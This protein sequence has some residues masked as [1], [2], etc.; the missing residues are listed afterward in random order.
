MD[1]SLFVNCEFSLVALNTLSLFFIFSALTII[2]HRKFIFCPCLLGV[3]FAS[4]ISMG[5]SFLNLGNF[6]FMILLKIWS[7]LLACES[8]P[9]ISQI[10]ML[11]FSPVSHISC[12]CLSFA[13][14]KVFFISYDWVVSLFYLPS[15]PFIL[16][17]TCSIILQVSPHDHF[18]WVIVI[19][20]SISSKLF[21]LFKGSLSWVQ[22][23]DTKLSF[24]FH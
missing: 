6:S 8:S 11:F 5:M 13:I 19:F 2:F 9:L 12:V 10:P 18:N 16:S 3:V 14:L 20:N 21:F 7:V 15:C 4:C 17:S 1:F 22:Y 23:S 24:P